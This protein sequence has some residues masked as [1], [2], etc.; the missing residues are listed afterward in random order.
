[1]A[2]Q[3][4]GGNALDDL[5]ESRRIVFRH[6][7]VVEEKQRFRPGAEGVVN[8][9][10]DQI[11]ADGVVDT[12]LLG[13]FELCANSIS[14]RDKHRVHIVARE[15]LA[16]KNRAGTGQQ[17]PLPRAEPGVNESALAGRVAGPSPCRTVQGQ[18]PN[19][20]KLF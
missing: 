19:L 10:G 2:L 17:I 13:D 7:H 6:C 8:T 11:D 20:Y 16:G 15:E 9:H 4:P 12:S 3:A 14:C 18:L 1:M 5:F